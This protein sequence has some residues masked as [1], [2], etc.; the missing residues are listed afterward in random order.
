V[1]VGA[2]QEETDVVVVITNKHG[3]IV[4]RVGLPRENGSQAT[5][6]DRF[7]NIKIKTCPQIRPLRT[8]PR[9]GWR[10]AIDGRA[11]APEVAAALDGHHQVARLVLQSVVAA[12]GAGPTRRLGSAAPSPRL[13]GGSRAMGGGRVAN[14]G[15]VHASRNGKVH[16]YHSEKINK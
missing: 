3:E 11:Y 15:R 14:E 5:K 7:I 10:K 6:R 2:G 13:A 4:K 9:A 12:R 16:I 1:G 8:D